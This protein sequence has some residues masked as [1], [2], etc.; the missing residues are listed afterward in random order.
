MS[1]RYDLNK[2]DLGETGWQIK[3]R[4]ARILVRHRL[5]ALPQDARIRISEIQSSWSDDTV[6]VEWSAETGAMFWKKS[7]GQG[8]I[9]T[10]IAEFNA[11][12]N[13]YC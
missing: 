10:T 2:M 6:R 13:R 4:A 11:F 5:P 9:T 12:M 7:S 3:T 8:V 1:D